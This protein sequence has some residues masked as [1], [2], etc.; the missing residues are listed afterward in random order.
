M[1]EA[2]KD[3]NVYTMEHII[4][5]AIDN[6]LYPDPSYIK[7]Q[8]TSVKN[9]FQSDLLKDYDRK[10][11]TFKALDPMRADGTFDDEVLDIWE[12]SKE[13]EDQ[14]DYMYNRLMMEKYNVN[15]MAKSGVQKQQWE[16][17]VLPKYYGTRETRFP[18]KRIQTGSV[19]RRLGIDK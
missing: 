13:Y 2:I 19:R 15:P 14:L 11:R 7:R 9:Q 17:Y 6:N 1:E 16:N 18:D 4:H 5:S 10:E 12:R 8:F 3:G